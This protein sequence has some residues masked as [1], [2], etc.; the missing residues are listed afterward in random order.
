MTLVLSLNCCK[1]SMPTAFMLSDHTC[2]TC[3][4]VK[5]CINIDAGIGIIA[6][7]L[8]IVVTVIWERLKP[9]RTIANIF[10]VS[11][12]MA[13]LLFLLVLPLNMPALNADGWAFER[14]MCKSTEGE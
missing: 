12:A 5:L 2:R 3:N 6:N 8:V 11:L 4:Q 10:V 1:S 9:N 14:F 7:A 13:D